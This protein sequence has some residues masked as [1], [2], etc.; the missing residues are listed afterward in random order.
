M[1]EW[2]GWVAERQQQA[3][4]LD[5]GRKITDAE[6]MMLEM[7][8][9]LRRV[10]QERDRAIEH[11]S[12]V[13]QAVANVNLKMCPVDQSIVSSYQRTATFTGM[14]GTPQMTPTEVKNTSFLQFGSA[15]FGRTPDRDLSPHKL[16]S[17]R[18]AGKHGAD[19][20]SKTTYQ[21]PWH[22]ANDVTGEREASAS[23][24]R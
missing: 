7:K 8:A 24:E 16:M 5:L 4:S 9:E 15:E 13:M 23:R 17:P 19:P 12:D 18:S 21:P 20:L 1:Q 14:A 10:E 22:Y 3:A 6:L 11:L 2:C